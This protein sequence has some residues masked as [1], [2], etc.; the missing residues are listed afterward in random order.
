MSQNGSLPIGQNCTSD[1]QCNSL[2]CGDQGTCDAHSNNSTG[3]ATCD[4][5][6]G[7]FCVASSWCAQEQVQDCRVIRT[8]QN[9]DTGA[10]TCALFCFN[11]S[12]NG[13]CVDNVCRSPVNPPVPAFDPNDCSG[14]EDP[15]IGS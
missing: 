12:Q 14:A 11:R 7:A 15:P 13:T 3:N 10:I 8:G 9:T 6:P 1:F 5:P 2:C 4:K